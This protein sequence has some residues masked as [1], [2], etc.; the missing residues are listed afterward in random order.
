[1]NDIEIG[2][3][4]IQC[5]NNLQIKNRFEITLLK[6]FILANNMD[7]NLK[8]I[9]VITTKV[10]KVTENQLLRKSEKGSNA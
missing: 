3:Q 7:L 5:L 9:E 2:F 10:Q 1:M 8:L 4:I 6:Y